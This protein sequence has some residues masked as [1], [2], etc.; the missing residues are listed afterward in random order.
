MA[1]TIEVRGLE[2]LEAKLSIPLKV[3]LAP[4]WMAIGQ[5]LKGLIAVYPGSVSYPIKW[6]NE[7]QRR[8]Y[9]A[10]RAGALPYVRNSDPTSQRLGAS[11][12]IESE[13]FGVV[14]GTRVTYAPYVQG[15][16]GQQ[17]MHA[18]TG[19]K[20]DEQAALELV[21]SG[22]IPRIIEAAIAAAYS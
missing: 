12:A 17:P 18:A 9:F 16:E 11:W 14:V 1:E 7:K 6:T 13:E 22:A 4:A 8:W 15:A 19:W 2:A 5:Q 3:V 21:A 20:T 10:H